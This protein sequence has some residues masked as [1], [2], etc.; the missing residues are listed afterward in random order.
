MSI[1]TSRFSSRPALA[2]YSLLTILA[3]AG[4]A[5][6]GAA[7]AAPEPGDDDFLGTAEV[8]VIVATTTVTDAGLASDVYGDVSLTS[9][10]PGAMQLQEDQN[11]ANGQVINGTIY[12][13]SPTPS[14]VAQQA[15]ADV[16][17]AYGALAGAAVDEVVG[18]V[19]LALIAGHQVGLEVV[20]EPGVYNSGSVILL[21][22]TIVLDGLNDLDSVF[23]FQAG[24]GL[25]IA[26]GA[27]VLLRNGAQSCNVYWKVGS[28]ATIE[29]GA[30][31]VGTV[32]SAGSIWARTG[33]TIDGQLLAGALGAGEVT[34]D[35]NVI[36]G[37]TLCIRSSTTT[38]GTT[39]TTRVDGTT[40]TVFT[41]PTLPTV[42]PPAPTTSTTS[43]TTSRLNRVV[44]T[45]RLAST[46]VEQLSPL[47]PALAALI[48]G[49]LLVGAGAW[50][51]AALLSPR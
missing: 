9:V 33:A 30:Q 18:A 48:L 38:A 13:D 44:A 25:T 6:V 42:T 3:I 29:T 2:G 47:L 21:D 23:I 5:G 34:L 10:A 37:Q 1:F 39:T 31:F 41:P 27:T 4:F 40:T 36:D 51:R 43:F 19:N 49:G 24:S 7:N 17:I 20:Y 28:D 50:R 46:G 35:H 11:V 26:S 45:D 22:G 32:V 15:T 8:F 14:A 12:V 16:G